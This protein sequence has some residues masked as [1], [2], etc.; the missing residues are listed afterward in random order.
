MGDISIRSKVPRSRIPRSL[1]DRAARNHRRW[2]YAIALHENGHLLCPYQRPPYKCMM[3]EIGA[4]KWA[5]CNALIW[6]P[7]MER[8][9]QQLLAWYASAN[10]RYGITN[11]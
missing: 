5:R 10:P 4:W 6:S 7:G 8:I 3:N 9:V 11:A 1:R 2:S